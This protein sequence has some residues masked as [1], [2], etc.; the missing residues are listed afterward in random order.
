M[1]GSKSVLFDVR[2]GVGH[3]TLNRPEQM[4]ALDLALLAAL[5]VAVTTCGDDPEVGAVLLSGAG[6]NFC[7][8]G[9]LSYFG[10][11]D[12]AAVTGEIRELAT[13]FHVVM[14]R[15][16]RLDVPVVVAV[17]GAAAGGG[18]SVA[19]AGDVV[20]A[21]DT[22]KFAV[23]YSAIGFSI[24]GGLSYSLPRLIGLRPALTLALT[25]RRLSAAEALDIGLISEVVPELELADRATA[26]ATAL[27][28]GPRRAQAHIKTLFRQSL[29]TTLETQLEFETRAIA[30]TSGSPDGREGVAAFL[31]KRK[32][33][34][35]G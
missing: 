14:S 12:D 26:L 11:M 30:E 19:C 6:K 21:A 29:D 8:G 34:F 33:H 35:K 23:A 24:D 22:A 4:N 9:D 15:L 3:I 20:L 1:T 7:G 10:A 5:K 27:A 2:D 16:M 17:Q 13:E 28:A 25:N 18:L 31:G 32:A